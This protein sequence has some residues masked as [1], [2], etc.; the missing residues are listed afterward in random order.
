MRHRVYPNMVG[1]DRMTQA[2]A[3]QRIAVMQAVLETLLG[4]QELEPLPLFEAAGK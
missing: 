1:S 3:D 4:L 2:N